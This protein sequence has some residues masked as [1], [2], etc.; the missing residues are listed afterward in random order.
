MRL[1]TVPDLKD[2]NVSL[3]LLFLH[4]YFNKNGQKTLKLFEKYW[5]SFSEFSWSMSRSSSHP[6]R[7][8]TRR[9][10]L[11]SF[12]SKSEIQ[13][14]SS[15]CARRACQDTSL[16][17]SDPSWCSRRKLEHHVSNELDAGSSKWATSIKWTAS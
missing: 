8:W 14:L 5:K 9:A 17:V 13:P 3:L 12:S 7:Q 2:L 15:F 10:A 11:G 16:P 1:S 4:I 6:R